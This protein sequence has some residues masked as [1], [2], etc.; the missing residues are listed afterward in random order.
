MSK[1]NNKEEECP[2]G[3]SYCTDAC[4]YCCEIWIGGKHSKH[5]AY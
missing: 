4:Q 5:C 1:N 2:R 3:M